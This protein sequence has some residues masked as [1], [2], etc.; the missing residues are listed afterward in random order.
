MEKCTLRKGNLTF[1]Y[2]HSGSFF[3]CK[4]STIYSLR[5]YILMNYLS[6]YLPTNVHTYLATYLL[7]RTSVTFR[8][9]GNGNGSVI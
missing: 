8:T 4:S 3:N 5:T 9:G 6:T 1:D 7:H 2:S